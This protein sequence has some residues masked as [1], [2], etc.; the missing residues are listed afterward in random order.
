MCENVCATCVRVYKSKRQQWLCSIAVYSGVVFPCAILSRLSMTLWLNVYFWQKHTL[1]HIPLPI[2]FSRNAR[3]GIIS[4]VSIATRQLTAVEQH[5]SLNGDAVAV[6]SFHRSKCEL[7]L[8]QKKSLSFS[9]VHSQSISCFCSNF[10]SIPICD[11]WK[12]WQNNKSMK[13]KKTG[14]K[15]GRDK[16]QN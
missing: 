5:K 16:K 2:E 3:F 12:K 14:R 9:P 6:L 1:S 7:K 10:H 13:Q 4:V 8:R 11:E 15:E